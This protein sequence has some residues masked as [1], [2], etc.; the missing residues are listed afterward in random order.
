VTGPWRGRQMELR[1]RMWQ[2]PIYGESRTFADPD[3]RPLFSLPFF[4][5]LRV[6]TLVNT[7]CISFLSHSL[8]IYLVRTMPSS[9]KIRYRRMLILTSAKSVPGLCHSGTPTFP[10]DNNIIREHRQS[11]RH[12][13]DSI[14]ESNSSDN[15][16]MHTVLDMLQCLRTFQI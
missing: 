6:C 8:S 13:T 16:Q 7:S 12:K 5:P 10:L 9:I 11:S 1:S 3:I 14:R 15:G 4:S 2:S